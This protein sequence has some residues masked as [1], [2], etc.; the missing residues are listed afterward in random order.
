MKR[1]HIA[2]NFLAAVACALLLVAAVPMQSAHAE[3][4]LAT[5]FVNTTKLNMRNGAGTGHAVVD[6][7]AKNTAVNIYEVVGTWIR[8]DVPSTGKSGFVSG[9]Y[10]TINSSSLTAYALGVTSGKVNLRKEATSKSESLAIVDGNSGITI[11]SADSK[12]G[13]YK[14]KVHKTG[15]E[16]YI[17]P[18]YIKLVSK[19]DKG[20][21]T[22]SNGIVTASSVNLRSGAG[23]SYSKVALLKKNDALNILEKS[24][25]WYK[26]TVVAT[27]KT[28]Y[29]FATYVKET[30]SVATPTPTGSATVTPAGSPTPTPAGSQAGKINAIGVNFRTGPGTSYK[31]IGQLG[32]DTAVT[33][34]GKSGDWYKIMVNS[35]GTTGYVFA[36]YITIVT[37]TPTPK[38]SAT[39]TPKPSGTPTPVPT[40]VPTA[41]PTVAPTVAPTRESC[42]LAKYIASASP[43]GGALF[44]LAGKSR[45]LAPK[46]R[47]CT[48]NQR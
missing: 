42:D 41:V 29:V 17:S 7:L 44:L 22:S 8:I 21:A 32:K 4:T 26:V 31:N 19:V 16:G 10:V 3:S 1:K 11:Y 14:V 5:G 36:K 2:R 13:W 45:K 47:T 23:T 39:P 34:L 46:G 25:D 18:S 6:T 37:T 43:S 30:S 9:K 27:G 40:A 28:G 38:P 33:V 48:K 15:K 12:T 24:G 35:T 20:S